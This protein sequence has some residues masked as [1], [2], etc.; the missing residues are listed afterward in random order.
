MLVNWLIDTRVFLLHHY[1]SLERLLRFCRFNEVT[2]GLW[3]VY[4]KSFF[5]LP[6]YYI[7]VVRIAHYT[8]ICVWPGT[9]KLCSTLSNTLLT[10]TMYHPKMFFCQSAAFIRSACC[11][12]FHCPFIAKFT[13]VQTWVAEMHI[14]FFFENILKSSKG[15]LL[16]SGFYAFIHM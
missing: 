11:F 15:N 12:Y 14:A 16:H 4:S 1:D 10:C 8:S 13:C 3:I 6:F 2:P 7:E 9:W 5:C